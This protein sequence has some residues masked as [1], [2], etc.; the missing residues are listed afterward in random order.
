MRIHSYASPEVLV[1]ENAPRPKPGEGK[2]LIRLQTVGV[3][4]IDWKGRQSS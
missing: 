2:V 4:P 3:N 1:Y